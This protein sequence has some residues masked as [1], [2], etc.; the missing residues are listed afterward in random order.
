V[1]NRKTQRRWKKHR[2]KKNGEEEEEKP[3]HYTQV[4]TRFELCNGYVSDSD[5]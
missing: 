5:L 2:E 4:K 3:H 1:E